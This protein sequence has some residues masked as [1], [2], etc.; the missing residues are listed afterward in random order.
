MKIQKSTLY[1]ILGLLVIFLPLAVI[2]T[3]RH[4][5]L[6]NLSKIDNPNKDFYYNGALYFYDDAGELMG[7]YTCQTTTCDYAKSTIDDDTYNINYA[8]EGTL[9]YVVTNNDNYVFINDGDKIILFSISNEKVVIEYT[10]VKDYHMPIENNYLI[11]EQDNKWGVLSLNTYTNVLPYEYDF[12]GLINRVTDD[13]LQADDFLVSAENK[14]YIYSSDG[15]AKNVGIDVPIIDY[16]QEYIIGSDKKIYNYQGTLVTT[17]TFKDAY[18]V[19]KYILL[20]TSENLV[21]VFDNFRHDYLAYAQISNYKSLSFQLDDKIIN[22]FVD[23]TMGTTID[24]NS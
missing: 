13:V 17:P 18:I 22:V 7:K 15:I 11:V 14:W 19:G 9:E 23:G 3:Y 2:G 4:I 6:E 10:A 20:I 5:Q 8:K 21:M 16:N 12:I 1:T 24:L